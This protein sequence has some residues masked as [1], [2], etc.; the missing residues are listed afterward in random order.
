MYY[1]MGFSDVA[2][3]TLKLHRW[4][5]AAGKWVAY[6]GTMDGALNLVSAEVSQLGTFAILE[7]VQPATYTCRLSCGEVRVYTGCLWQIH[8]LGGNT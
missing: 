6:E 1:P 8:Y 7:S 4:D 5:T 2:P 3:G